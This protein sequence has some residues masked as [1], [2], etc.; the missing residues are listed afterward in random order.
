[1]LVLSV[2]SELKIDEFRMMF[3]ICLFGIQTKYGVIENPTPSNEFTSNSR[4]SS[5]QSEFLYL[6]KCVMFQSFEVAYFTGFITV[7]FIP[8][9]LAI[10]F[11]SLTLQ[12]FTMF[13]W[14]NTITIM[15]SHY[16]QMRSIELQFNA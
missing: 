16:L 2:S 4:Y 13:L 11:D 5:V 6:I 12:I 9:D 3:E 7:K 10:Y 8:Y 1:M 15:S 14:I